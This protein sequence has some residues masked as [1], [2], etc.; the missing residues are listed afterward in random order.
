MTYHANIH[1]IPETQEDIDAK[2]QLLFK[3]R[4]ELG[5]QPIIWFH[6][7][8]GK[9]LALI[10]GFRCWFCGFTFCSEC[11]EKHFGK[12]PLMENEYIQEQLK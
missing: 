7:T 11:A 2:K 9:S 1:K 4:K 8:C 12:K 5:S 6:C 3:Q 10:M